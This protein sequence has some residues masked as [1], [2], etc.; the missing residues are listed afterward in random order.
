MARVVEERG[1]DEALQT[2]L[3]EVTQTFNSPDVW[4]FKDGETARPTDRLPPEQRLRPASH[5]APPPPRLTRTARSLGLAAQGVWQMS[6]RKP[7]AGHASEVSVATAV[8]RC[9]LNQEASLSL[10]PTWNA[11][12]GKVEWA[13]KI[14]GVAEAV[15]SPSDVAHLYLTPTKAATNKWSATGHSVPSLLVSCF[16]DLQA[17]LRLNDPDAPMPEPKADAEPPK[18]K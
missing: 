9:V 7:E 4:S 13:V 10:R 16:E 15:M 3:G 5:R 6:T 8:A 2:T 12:S 11:T 1:G 18:A 14:E 17:P